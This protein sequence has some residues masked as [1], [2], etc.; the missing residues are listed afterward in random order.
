M[1]VK[2]GAARLRESLPR[3]ITQET[4]DRIEIVAIDSG[5]TDDT[6]DV[7]KTFGATILAIDPR[8]FDHGLTRNAAAG[9]ARGDVY[10]FLNQ[11]ALPMDD[12]WLSKLV[13]PLD[14]D[15]TLAGVCSRVVARPGA[16]PITRKDVRRDLSGSTERSV[17]SIESISKYQD[18]TPHE[19]RVFV[20]FH[21]VS[22]A[23][24]PL[25]FAKIPFRTI[26]MGEDVLW[27]REVLEAGYRIQHEP[28]S[29][30]FHSHSYSA[31]EILRRNVDDGLVNRQIVGRD[32][33]REGIV[34]LIQAL[35]RDDW[36]YLE[37]EEKLTGEELERWK[38]ESVLRRAA[39]AVGQWVGANADRTTANLADLLSLTE[40]IKTDAAP[41]GKLHT[42]NG[43]D[44]AQAVTADVG[45]PGTSA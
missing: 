7:M 5:S 40:A 16:D 27:A 21:T 39:L 30:V 36:K 18:L 37:E 25:V 2:N 14:E 11:S 22:A 41:P 15:Q 10:V 44:A 1:P 4:S 3:V 33:E 26:R 19:R 9:Y 6:I 8:D 17:K 38:I 35:V 42:A 31:F 13:A 29:R 20:N 24:R 34:P 23:I 45:A 28:D 43:A 12:Q 32:F